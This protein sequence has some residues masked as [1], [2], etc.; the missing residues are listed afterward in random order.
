MAAVP[1]KLKQF[2]NYI[3]F[4]DENSVLELWLL[5][6]DTTFVAGVAALQSMLQLS[7]SGWVWSGRWNELIYRCKLAIWGSYDSGS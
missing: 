6:A 2:V 5:E 7:S 4:V 3:M 1:G